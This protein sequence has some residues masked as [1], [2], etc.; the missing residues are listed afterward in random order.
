MFGKG[1][2]KGLKVT[3]GQA[4]SRRLTEKYPEEKPQL[5]E[6]WRGGRFV[7]DKEACINCGLCAMSCPNKVIRQ[8]F[9]KDEDNKKFCTEFV[10]D[11]QYCL[12]CGLCVEACPKNC[13]HFTH[14]FETAV[15]DPADIPQDL[16]ADNGS[17]AKA[18]AYGKKPAPPKPAAPPAEDKGGAE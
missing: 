9:E 4:L 2:L 13:L 15:Y 17:A 14:D 5:P 10:I 11:R 6:R 18:S 7:L 3:A 8:T 1:V 12:F 16:L